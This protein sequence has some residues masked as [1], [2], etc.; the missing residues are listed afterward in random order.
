MATEVITVTIIPYDYMCMINFR[1]Q[2]LHWHP[3]CRTIRYLKSYE[4]GLISKGQ[5]ILLFYFYLLWVHFVRRTNNSDFFS[6]WLCKA[7]TNERCLFNCI[8]WH[9]VISFYYFFFVK[10]L[11]I[12]FRI[13]RFGRHLIFLLLF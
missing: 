7:K 11:W 1:F 4:K 6:S 12:S 3:Q 8:L 10:F 13:L 5:P 2:L 9:C